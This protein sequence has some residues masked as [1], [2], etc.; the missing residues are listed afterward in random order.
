M[1]VK[2]IDQ[3]IK[4][5]LA[6]EEFLELRFEIMKDFETKEMEKKMEDLENIGSK[7]KDAKKRGYTY[8]AKTYIELTIK[9]KLFDSRKMKGKDTMIIKY[10]DEWSMP[11]KF[12]DP[13]KY[14]TGKKE[15]KTRFYFP[16][17]VE[18]KEAYKRML[19]EREDGD[20]DNA[21]KVNFT[22][23]SGKD[24]AMGEPIYMVHPLYL[25]PIMTNNQYTDGIKQNETVRIYLK[26]R[27]YLNQENNGKNKGHMSD[28]SKNYNIVGGVVAKNIVQITIK[29]MELSP[30][31]INSVIENI[32]FCEMLGYNYYSLYDVFKLL[33]TVDSGV[34][35][36]DVSVLDFYNHQQFIINAFV[37]LNVFSIKKGRT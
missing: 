4:A 35:I 19:L 32:K 17:S 3:K 24:I 23:N 33:Q 29:N 15:F 27:L 20:I 28:D 30:F 10:N 11:I 25:V 16:T 13:T 7:T 36:K 34:N 5:L 31:D 37:Q 18:K 6:N 1:R 9:Q 26:G 22:N 12:E 2:I 8:D 21:V 14:M